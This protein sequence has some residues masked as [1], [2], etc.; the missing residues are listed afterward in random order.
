LTEELTLIN[1]EYRIYILL[2]E[3]SELHKKL[4]HYLSE[5]KTEYI[6]YFGKNEFT[7]WWDKESLKKYEFQKIKGRVS[8]SI[9]IK[10]VF[11]REATLKGH[12]EIPVPD[13]M[14]FALVE[15]PFLYFERLPKGFDVRLMQYDLAEFVYSSYLIKNS[16]ALPNLYHLKDINEYVQLL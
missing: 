7:A 4:F 12:E 5:G 11:L 8:G 10:S 3:E 6:P 13:M 1:P 15:N 9:K 16:F 14:N 2:S